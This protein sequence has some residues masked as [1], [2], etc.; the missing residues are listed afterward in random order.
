MYPSFNSI[1][2]PIFLKA[3]RCISIG[4]AP[5][6]HPPG[7]ETSTFPNLASNGPITKTLALIF[8]T[9]S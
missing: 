2:A 3:S 7:K 8:L 1:L 9:K 5:I 4:L 6:E